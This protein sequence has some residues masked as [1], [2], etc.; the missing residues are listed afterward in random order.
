MPKELIGKI[1]L[2]LSSIVLVL[3]TIGSTMPKTL[4]G[5][6]TMNSIAFKM[7]GGMFVLCLSLLILSLFLVNS[8]VGNHLVFLSLLL[9]ICIVAMWFVMPPGS[10]HIKYKGTFLYKYYPVQIPFFVLAATVASI[11]LGLGFLLKKKI[12]G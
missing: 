8:P 10:E 4:G 3:I 1:L 2:W 7:V 5:G 11:I 12:I 9:F 6:M